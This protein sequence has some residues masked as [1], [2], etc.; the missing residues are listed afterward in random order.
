MNAVIIDTNGILGLL[1]D[2]IPQQADKVEQLIKKSKRDQR[3]IIIPEAVVFEINFI[4]NKYYKVQKK[5]IIEKLKS[6]L[7]TSYF[8][9][10]SK[11]IF[12]QALLHYD[13]NNISLVDCFL[14]AKAKLGN[15]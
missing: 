6:L 11:D 8:F 14:I 5:E 7:A 15:A 3:K 9:V 12:S 1:L 2:D 10:E 13:A 4:L